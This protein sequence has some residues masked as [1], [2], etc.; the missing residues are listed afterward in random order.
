MSRQLE[1]EELEPDADVL[2][3]V[4]HDEPARFRF[5][6]P[7][8]VEYLC[9]HCTMVA[10]T[11]LHNEQLKEAREG[12][13]IQWHPRK[14]TDGIPAPTSAD[15]VLIIEYFADAGEYEFAAFSARMVDEGSWVSADWQIEDAWPLVNDYCVIRHRSPQGQEA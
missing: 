6:L 13:L 2:C 14:D 3:T 15:D 9:P 1:I 11:D 10:M 5:D 4:C 7:K 12:R 8:K